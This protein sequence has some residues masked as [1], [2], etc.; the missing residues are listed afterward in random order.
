MNRCMGN[1]QFNSANSIFR[2]RD[3]TQAARNA[4]RWPARWRVVGFL[5][6]VERGWQARA[7]IPVAGLKAEARTPVAIRPC[8][9]PAADAARVGTLR[10]AAA[11]ND[12]APP[13]CQ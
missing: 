3:S 8:P 9:L 2:D 5:T 10:A 4:I 13:H 6:V 11:S 1:L 7:A 12:S